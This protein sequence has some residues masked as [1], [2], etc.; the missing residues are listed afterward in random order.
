MKFH[1][2]PALYSSVILHLVVLAALL[3]VTLVEAFLP[4]EDVHVFEMINEPATDDR[5]QESL[6]KKVTQNVP[7]PRIDPIDIPQP[8]SQLTPQDTADAPLM[9]LEDFNREYPDSIKQPKRRKPQ[10]NTPTVKAPVI[11]TEQFSKRLESN[12]ETVN[13]TTSNASDAAQQEALQYY[14]YQLNRRLNKVWIKPVNLTGINLVAEVRFDVS[15]AGHISNI[16]FR[17]GSGNASFD[18]SIRAAFAR[19]ASGGATPTGKSH[20]FTLSFKMVN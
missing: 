11:N 4:K 2:H 9:S 6:P 8:T 17:P 16:Q 12:L 19:V 14:A 7:P 15:S 18:E 3:V 1:H 10:A 13:P 20:T 5:T